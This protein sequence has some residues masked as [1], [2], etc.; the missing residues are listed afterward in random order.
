MGRVDLNQKLSLTQTA[1]NLSQPIL[2]PVVKVLAACEVHPNF[3]TIL[4]FLGFIGSSYFIAKGNFLVAGILI[5]V[6]GPL[7]AIDGAL[8]RAS[9]KVTPFGAFLDSTLDRYGE[10]F[11]FLGLTYFFSSTNNFWGV[12]LSFLAITGSLMVSYTRARAE[13]VGFECKI[14]LLTRFERL[15]LITIGLIFQVMLPVLAFISV[16]THFTALQRMYYVYKQYKGR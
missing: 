3:V 10:I 7:D 2:N 4:C 13:G 6:F 15:L 11:L 8:A 9:K 12:L 14:G 16:F 1:R 5:A